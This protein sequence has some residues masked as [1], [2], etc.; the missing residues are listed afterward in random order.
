MIHPAKV[1][2]YAASALALTACAS[3]PDTQNDPVATAVLLDNTGAP[4]SEARLFAYDETVE[5]AVTVQGLA[6]GEHGF[7][8][9]TTGRCALPDFTSAG[10]HLNPSDEGHGLLDDDGSHMGDLP[11]LVVGA[12][13]TATTR[14]TIG[15]PRDYVL[16]SIFDDDG[17]AVVIHAKPD[18]GRTDPSG[19]AG[20]RERCGVL[21]PTT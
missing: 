19:A 18:D 15:G 6:P 3:V 8:L 17:T 2:F 5:L 10:G 9:H 13:G 7:H 4:T 21:E 12:N 11:N 20:P 14:V 16:E 1:T